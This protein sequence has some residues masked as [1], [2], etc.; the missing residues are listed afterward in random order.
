MVDKKSGLDLMAPPD[1]RVDRYPA[2]GGYYDR[3]A[4]D[5]AE[6]GEQGEYQAE[7]RATGGGEQVT[8]ARDLGDG[9]RLERTVFVP[10][11]DARRVVV[12]SRL[13]NTGSVPRTALLQVHPE[14]RVGEF[15][16]C[17]FR[18]KLMDGSWVK[19][20][21]ADHEPGR[22]WQHD[23]TGDRRPAGTWRVI[24]K[25]QGVELAI[26]FYPDEVER[27][28]AEPCGD[29]REVELTLFSPARELAPGKAITI[30]HRWYLR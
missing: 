23:L 14:V 30:K 6:P 22:W 1:L 10:A 29:C 2:S 9:L 26:R 13:I 20:P 19:D 24:N 5:T 7:K 21:F 28:L 16:N 11:G 15:E 4:K 17:V 3:T 25:P 18:A 8:L 27:A 12:T